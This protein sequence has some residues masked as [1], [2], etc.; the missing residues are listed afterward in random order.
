MYAIY[1]YGSEEQ[2]QQWLPADGGRR[3]DRLLR[4][5]RARLRL[6]PRRACAPGRVRDGDD[7][8]LNGTQDVDHQRLHRRR[9]RRLGADRR[10]HPRLR[11][12][13]RHARASRPRDQAQAVA[14]RLG[15]QR[16]RARRR[17][18]ARATR[19]CPRST[20]SRA[21]VV[22]DRGAL[23]HRLG[24]AGRRPRLPARP[25]S[26][27]ARDARAV[28]PADRAASSSPRRSSPTWP[29]ELQQ[30]ACCSRCTSAGSRTPGALR[31][32]QVSARQA[33]QRPRGARHRPRVPHHPR[34]Q[35]HHARVPASCATPTTSS[36]C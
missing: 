8:V 16:A 5:D 12:A 32:E 14:A 6:R 3:G 23:R 30:G 15:H 11:R 26:T 24:R 29:L 19:C 7:W 20:G 21:A 35:R 34:R 9:R 17:A 33:Q 36:R 10:R 27:Y 22:P 4:P 25:R 28:R 31:P 2:K 18:P 1:R 13:D